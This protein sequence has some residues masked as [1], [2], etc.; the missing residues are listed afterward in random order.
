MKNAII[1]MLFLSFTSIFA[2]EKIDLKLNLKVGD[3]IPLQTDANAEIPVQVEGITR[4]QG[5]FGAARGSSAV[6]I[7]RIVENKNKEFLKKKD[8][9]EELKGSGNLDDM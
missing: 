4:F 3:V 5:L 9:S 7:T 2:Q 6:Q 8:E 1:I